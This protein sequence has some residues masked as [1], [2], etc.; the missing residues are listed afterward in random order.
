M[1]LCSVC[2]SSQWP[3]HLQRSPAKVIIDDRG[4]GGD[5]EDVLQWLLSSPENFQQAATFH[6]DIFYKFPLYTITG[7]HST[8]AQQVLI[9]AGKEEALKDKTRQVIVYRASELTD[10]QI[11]G[12]SKHDNVLDKEA[13]QFQTI[14]FWQWL[15]LVHALYNSEGRPKQ[16]KGVGAKKS[17]YSE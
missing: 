10:F 11:T 17:G 6:P 4:S 9:R 13:A 1:Q 5:F 16:T 15:K 8:F 3:F 14:D 7:Q 12:M 2:W